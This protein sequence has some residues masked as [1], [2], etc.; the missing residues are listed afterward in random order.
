MSYTK[1]FN[2]EIKTVTVLR[3]SGAINRVL[4]IPSRNSVLRRRKIVF[5][6]NVT[7][8]KNTAEKKNY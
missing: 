5:A 2:N 8:S 3:H 1:S 7:Y 4:R 6:R